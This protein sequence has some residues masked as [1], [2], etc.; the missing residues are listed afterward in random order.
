MNVIGF[1]ISISILQFVLIVAEKES[2]DLDLSV[3]FSC[4]LDGTVWCEN[5]TVIFL[6]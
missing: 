1:D 2:S 4:S 6:A 3:V 5:R